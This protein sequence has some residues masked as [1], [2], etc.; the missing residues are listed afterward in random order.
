MTCTVARPESG[1]TF[2][3]RGVQNKRSNACVE[4]AATD[5]RP[6][7]ARSR[8][9]QRNGLFGA[10]RL[11]PRSCSEPSFG[12]SSPLHGVVTASRKTKCDPPSNGKTL[13]CGRRVALV[14]GHLV[15]QGALKRRSRLTALDVSIEHRESGHQISMPNEP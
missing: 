9:A 2:V 13:R 10:M 11:T 14:V 8:I 5:G 7:L 3:F 12:R 15:A 4:R 6:G 1:S